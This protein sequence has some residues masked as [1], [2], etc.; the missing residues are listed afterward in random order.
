VRARAA[1][2]IGVGALLSAAPGAS[3]RTLFAT[4]F[5]NSNEVRGLTPWGASLALATRG[6]VVLFDPA[7]G[8]FQ[9][10][11]RTPQGLPSNDVR[12]VAVGPSGTLWAGTNAGGLARLKPGGGFRRT[13]TTFDGLPSDIVT[14]IYVHGDSVWV[15]TSGGVALFT[16]NAA[17]GQIA[18]RRADTKAR[19]GGGLIGDQIAGFAV[20]G[21]TLW[22]ATSA[23]MSIFA[24]GTWQARP[25]AMTG[26]IPRALVVHE[27]T[28]WAATS[29]GPYR[30]VSGIFSPVT[31]GHPGGG[32]WAIRS[33]GGALYSGANA[34]SVN[35]Y[36]GGGWTIV[37]AAGSPPVAVVDVQGTYDGVLYAATRLG[38]VRYDAAL[39]RWAGLISPGP[40]T[41]TFL[42]PSVR[43]AAGDGGVWFTTG[44]AGAVLHYD[45]GT[46]ET[47]TSV[48]TGGQL[49]NS[50]VFGLLLDRSRRVWL[51]HCCSGADP[52][53]RLDRFDPVANQWDRPPGTNLI[54]LAQSP[55]GPVYAGS[56]EFGNGLYEYD[57]ST[58]ALLDSLTPANTQGATGPGLTSNILRAVAFDAAGKG[59]IALR[60]FGLDIWDGRGTAA[61]GD[62]IWTHVGT[63]L[64]S[65]F[66]Y[67]LAVESPSRAWLG[68]VAGLARI[69]NGLV[70]R[71]WT[72]TTVP[73]LPSPQV[74]D[75]A[76]DPQ[77]NLWIATTGGISL[78][79]RDG[80]LETFTVAN[81]LVD[82]AVACLAWD[83]VAGAMWAGT[84]HGI[85]R[86]VLGGGPGPGFSSRT[87][88]Y[89]NPVR[90]SDG[91]LKLGGVTDAIRGEVRDPAG[92]LIHRFH[93]DPTSN[94]IWD[95]RRADGG[96][97]APGIYLVQLRD[98]DATRIL[99]V[100]VLR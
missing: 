63:G 6:G 52:R 3:A 59:W 56:V 12:C 77:G 11:L 43:A 40:L 18:L 17:S 14:T 41:D 99:R 53:P 62:D 29:V 36:T 68:T 60:D 22:C 1:V 25:A 98:G 21:D 80:S 8:S 44:N 46:W 95:L 26:A 10:I 35:R 71:A 93:A 16:E 86:L 84:A 54:T 15:G 5:I 28:L 30:Y 64:P 24:Q 67:S 32:S 69:E 4:S 65:A 92:R 51:G 78:L 70:T 34:A 50:G 72:T 49:D 47:L 91:G 75:L 89:P 100:A 38:L 82:D 2:A 58:G 27:D 73:A 81:G 88:V 31:G 57:E 39:D 87:Y 7:T 94:V 45:G 76:L 33:I 90:D 42:P 79:A 19:T 61:H 9:K 74:N 83:A 20:I 66:S 23:G 97:A 85:S 96:P 55:A 37:G 48:S 13:L